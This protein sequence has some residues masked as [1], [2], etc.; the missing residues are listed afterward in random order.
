MRVCGACGAVAD[1]LQ[2]RHS[3]MRGIDVAN[4]V[5]SPQKFYKAHRA[6]RKFEKATDWRCHWMSG[7]FYYGNI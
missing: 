1:A 4:L 6:H 2:T 5:F 7:V 3:T